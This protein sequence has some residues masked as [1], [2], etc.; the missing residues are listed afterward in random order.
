MRR[1]IR[2]LAAVAVMAGASAPGTAAGAAP[3]R[4]AASAA[5]EAPATYY[6]QADDPTRVE[7]PVTINAGSGAN[8]RG[9][10][11][12]VDAS[13]VRGLVRLQAKR[14]CTE[15]AGYVFTCRLTSS[16]GEFRLRD[17]VVLGADKKAAPGTHGTVF[18]RLATA[19]GQ[20]AEARTE[21]TAGSPE[22]WGRKLAFHDA[23][24]GKPLKIRGGVL[25]HGPFTASGFRVTVSALTDT[26]LR[27]SY[28]N[29]RYSET[30]GS[31]A[32]CVFDTPLEPGRAYLFDA[33]FIL[34]GESELTRGTAVLTVFA[35]G[36]D[37]GPYFDEAV[38][39]IPGEGPALGLTPT[40]P[41]GFAH[42]ADL[43]P[44]ETDQH[45]DVQAVA[46]S[47]D[48]R[49]GDTV[50]LT[51]GV[52]N[53]G[54][55][56]I[57]ARYVRYEITP[58]DGTTLIPPDKPSP[59]PDED[60]GSYWSCS[61]WKAGA[62]HYSCDGGNLPPGKAVTQVL[63]FRI[64]SAYAGT[65]KVTAVLRNGYASHDS[66]PGNNTAEITVA[67][68]EAGLGGRFGW[69]GVAAA[70]FAAVAVLVAGVAYRRRRAAR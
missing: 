26:H 57:D 67:G 64:D 33:P 7:L 59:D 5:V 1:W 27:H 49:P 9:A 11:L 38:Y 23:P 20:R 6:T 24:A 18:F 51:V 41:T 17:L 46:G 2:L 50:E 47:L 22:L 48:G 69:A 12:T 43:I 65:G 15:G 68:A 14:V 30:G 66:R 40:E 62:A 63:R 52:R 13:R 37:A 39:T 44:V 31:R 56:R 21:M 35:P 61:P 19:G 25:N 54:P 8:V 29:C 70:G 3:D 58:P 36:Q 32:Y 10:V 28:S 53:A 34:E 4:A 16:Q 45:I 60:E 42:L 55:G